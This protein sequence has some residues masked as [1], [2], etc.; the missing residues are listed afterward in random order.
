MPFFDSGTFVAQPNVKEIPMK[1][2]NGL[3]LV[4]LTAFV[5]V[6]CGK[7]DVKN[8]VAEVTNSIDVKGRWLMVESSEANKVAKALE[9]ESMVL[10]F[11]DGKA[12]FAPTDSLKGKAVFAGLSNCT[13]GPRPYHTDKNDLVFDAVTG[14]AEKKVTVATLNATTLAFAD[15]EKPTITRTFT[16]IDEAKFQA[17]VKPADRKL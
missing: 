13:A 10:T 17:I 3:K 8:K 4:L 11:K 6:G 7:E 15:P 9:K 2:K 12:A 1:L 16:K 14:C 5:L